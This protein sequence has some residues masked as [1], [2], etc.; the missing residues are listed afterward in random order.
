MI[1]HTTKTCSRCGETF[2]ATSDYYWIDRSTKDGLYSRCK[3]CGKGKAIREV[4]PEGTKRC[5]G[6]K[7]V[8]P[9]TIEHFVVRS[10]K[11]SSLRNEC[12][13]CYHKRQIKWREDNQQKYLDYHRQYRT[14]NAEQVSDAKKSWYW[15]NHNYARSMQRT[16]RL[17]NVEKCREKASNWRRKNPDSVR[18]SSKVA[19]QKRR[20]WAR[21]AGGTFDANDLKIQYD[22]QRGLCWWCGKPVG[23]NYHADHRIPLSRGGT[24]SA[25]N[26]CIA[27]PDCNIRRNDKMPW[28]WNGRLL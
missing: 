9:H 1:D 14:E 17:E 18:R 23:N 28:E 20:A 21:K 24:N 5:T 27:C 13:S 12:I 19:K 6:C 26:I 10:R 25:N 3:N 11:D 8:F 2:P 22:M 4:L 7:Q 15:S 16:Y